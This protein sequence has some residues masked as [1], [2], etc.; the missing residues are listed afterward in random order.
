M[1]K[2][3]ARSNGRAYTLTEKKRDRDSLQLV[4]LGVPVR[5]HVVVSNLRKKK[6]TKK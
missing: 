1:V 4:N 2:L 6:L 5:R 3:Q